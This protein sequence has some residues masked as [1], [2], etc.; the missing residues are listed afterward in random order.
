[1]KIRLLLTSFLFIC[2]FLAFAQKSRLLKGQLIDSV[3]KEA[4]PFAT[5]KLLTSESA[6]PIAGQISNELG[7][8][9]F[10]NIPKNATSIQIEYIGY[11]S[12]TIALQEK[13][14]VMDLGEIK[15]TP[16]GQ[17][18]ESVTVTG[19]RPSVIS[20]LEKQVFKSDQFEV[21]K[22]GTA[23]DLL[24]NI[25][26]ISVNA[27]G[28]LSMRGSKGFL[29]LI[30]GKPTQVDASTIL[31]Q[32]PA[33]TIDKIELITAP[34]AKYDADGK[35]GI[36]NIVTK[37][38]NQDGWS[39]NANLQYGA[40]RIKEYENATEPIRQGVDVSANYFKGPWSISTSLNYLKNDIAGQRIGDVN[41]TLNSI[42]TS[43]PSEGERSFKRENRGIR[44][45]IIF[46][47]T[48][49]DE[50]VIGI[51]LGE[52]D[53]F[54]TADILYNNTKT[55]LLTNKIIG[56]NTYFNS[57]VV[58]KSGSFQVYN[59][60]YTHTFKNAGSIS[61]SGLY[62]YA[63]IDGYTK[64]R[65][66]RAK[67]GFDTLQYTLNTGENPLNAFRYKIDYERKIGIGKLSFGYQYRNQSQKGSFNYF[68][69]SGSKSAILFNPDFSANIDVINSIH[70]L[71]TQYG[72]TYKKLEFSTGLRY[73][74]AFREFKSNRNNNPI[75]LNLSNFF[76]SANLL[77][78]LQDD[79]RIKLA[80]SK[81]VQRSTNNE[82]NPYPEREHSETLEQGDPTIL[83]EFINLYE[84]GLVKEYSKA[85]L[86]INLYT[87]QIENIVNRVNSAYNDTILNRIYTNAGKASLIGSDFGLTLMP[88]KK[89]KFFFGGNIYNLKITG[90]LFNNA[91]AVNSSGWVYS[92]NSNLSYQM[93]PSMSAQ[94][95]L[96]YLSAKKTAQGLDSPFYQ[97]N[98]SLKKSFLSNKLTLTAQW[99]NVA[100]GNMKVNE[101]SISTKGANFYTTTNYVQERNIIL[102]NIAYNFWSNEK[103][104]K[105]PTSEFGEKEF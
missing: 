22:G 19:L 91:V 98:F 29:I 77:Y 79:L 70:G 47:P 17:Q 59:L 55:N 11:Q 56:R 39:L 94:V 72:G 78:K 5:I 33:N 13:N 45:S 31:A 16:N 58:R 101:Q 63:V 81:R 26:S 74:S 104:S 25:P 34:S 14:G 76:P 99:Q 12:K 4:L 50:L 88:H 23:S 42:F 21:A 60:D 44:S 67:N 105:L 52:K 69:K 103:K 68:E 87:Q 83:P 89:L 20:T 86:Y 36:I 10:S 84:T 95:N 30:N 73:E 49:N 24:K 93:N 2:S 100:I 3:S 85:S 80:Y 48:T 54:R 96:S 6:Q 9:E 40:P 65:N 46:S 64:N 38:G 41:T 62:E 75:L 90:A 15:L 61:I 43:F 28:E 102:L 32:I 53:Q 27:E 37:Q 18:L 7:Y 97:P 1:M 51:Y 35:S 66:L 8:F 82:L 71:Y 92:V 57:N